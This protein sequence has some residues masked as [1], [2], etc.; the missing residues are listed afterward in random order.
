V[1]LCKRNKENIRETI[2]F[3]KTS[4]RNE[5]RRIPEYRDYRDYRNRSHRMEMTWT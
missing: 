4:I 2:T 5:E 3:I 1:E